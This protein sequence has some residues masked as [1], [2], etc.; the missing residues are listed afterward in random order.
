KWPYGYSRYSFPFGFPS[1]SGRL[2]SHLPKRG[3]VVVFRHPQEDEDLIKRVIGLPG[4]TIAMSDGQ[5]I[6]N[7]KPVERK[8]LSPFGIPISA[9]SSCKVVPPAI[10][11]TELRDGKPYCS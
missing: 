11:A 8:K 1:F 7:G 6:L 2:L 3:D 9:N 10:P 5:L 4:D